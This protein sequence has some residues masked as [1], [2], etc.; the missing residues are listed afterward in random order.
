ML[1]NP[2]LG[3]QI[4]IGE[5]LTDIK[6]EPD[7]PVRQTCSGCDKCISACPTGAL[8][9]DGGFDANKCISYLTIEYEGDI[10]ADLADRMDAHLFGCDECILACPY[11]EKAPT[12]TNEDFEF[13]SQWKYLD[14]N[15]I[16]QMNNRTFHTEFAGSSL[17]RPGL[18]VLKRNARICLKNVTE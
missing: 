3:L 14:L 11:N 8:S 17:I 15:H 7:R 4:L 18:E 16:L 12:R 5:L 2:K 1:I 10:P 13:H 6:L 9:P